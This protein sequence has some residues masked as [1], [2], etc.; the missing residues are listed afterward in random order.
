[1]LQRTRAASVLPVW[2]RFADKYPRPNDLQQADA[3]ELEHLMRPLGL[4]WRIRLVLRL[5]HELVK[6]GGSVPTR[7]NDLK[8]MSAVGEY[9]ASA[10]LSLHCNKRAVLIDANVVRWICRMTGDQFDGET[11]R[12]KWLRGLAE[13]LTPRSTFRDFNFGVLDLTMTA[14]GRQPT[15][16]ICP[17]RRWCHTGTRSRS[18]MPKNP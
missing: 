15:C 16:S 8:R 18:V 4:A 10:F 6:Q 3:G 2:R 13:S 5:A 14:C 9:A 1:M 7:Q 11:R 12:K 17:V